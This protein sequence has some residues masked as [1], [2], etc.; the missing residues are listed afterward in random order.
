MA[1]FREDL[2]AVSEG[3]EPVKA[4]RRPGRSEKSIAVLPFIND[5]PDPAKIRTIST[6]IR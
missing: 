1:E 5:S 4:T 6:S 2:G 3:L